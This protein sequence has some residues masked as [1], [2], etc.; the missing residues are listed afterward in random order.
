MFTR[1]IEVICKPGKNKELT[2]LV[3]DK[4]TPILRKQPGFVDEV[5][6]TSEMEPNRGLAISFWNS[7]EDAERYNRNE[8]PRIHEMMQPLLE[9]SPIVKTY[10]VELSTV[11]KVAAGKAA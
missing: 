8:F 1:T 11:H 3:R 10:N 2:D 9:T 5:I 7:R 4:I 6:L